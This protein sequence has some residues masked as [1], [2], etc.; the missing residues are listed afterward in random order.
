MMNEGSRR[1]DQPGNRAMHIRPIVTEADYGRALREV[2]TY[3]DNEPAPGTPDAG[4]FDVL[5]ALIGQYEALH[6]PIEAPPPPAEG[7]PAK[8]KAS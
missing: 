1:Q 7:T 6:W 8:T 3:F 5:S 4:R 2:E